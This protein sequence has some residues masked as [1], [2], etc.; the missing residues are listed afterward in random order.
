SFYHRT[1]CV[2]E[3]HKNFITC[4]RADGKLSE[5][6]I[7][8]AAIKGI[9]EEGLKNVEFSKESKTICDEL[10]KVRNCENK[11]EIKQCAVRLYTHNGLLCKLVNQAL[12][13]N[14]KRIYRDTLGPYC[15]LLYSYLCLRSPF[16]IDF[17]RGT[18]YRGAW[19]HPG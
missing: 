9:E 17:H 3:W 10:H 18:V 14:D 12:R 8:D 6:D 13:K 1:L 4:H 19:L 11:V 5:K 16:G 7:I 2:Q 15:Y